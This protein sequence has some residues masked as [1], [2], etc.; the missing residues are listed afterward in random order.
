[1]KKLLFPT[2]AAFLIGLLFP[3]C[4]PAPKGGVIEGTY[5][6]LASANEGRNVVVSGQ[7]ALYTLIFDKDK[8]SGTAPCNS[9]FA[10]FSAEGTNLTVSD[11]GSTKRMCDEIDRENAYLGMLIKAQAYS[12]LK[13]RLE[14][15]GENNQLTFVP[16]TADAR[17]K[18]EHDKGVGLLEAI[19][20]V[21]EGDAVPHLYPI[22]RVDNPG[23]YP[24]IGS[25][26]DTSLYRYFDAETVSVWNNAGGEVMAVGQYGGLF[27]C[28]IPGR[29]V[30]SDIALFRNDGNKMTRL[31]IIAWAWCDEGWCNQQD[32][33][34]QDV[35]GDGRVDVIQHYTLTDDKGKIREER[36]T[37]LVQDEE[38]HFKEDK[39]L[40]PNKAKFEMA[41]I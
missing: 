25:L 2:C 36:M 40:K 31:E 26:V 41:K 4:K 15:Y 17:Q 20:P 35:N 39:S 16:M 5:W 9:Y 28:R 24:F 33:W 18:I 1:M 27:I 19:F 13:D 10:G 14:I 6:T 3:S 23:N 7:N 29:Y 32:A 22:L 38:G 12:V 30:S 8:L 21:L 34:L 11:L 37:V